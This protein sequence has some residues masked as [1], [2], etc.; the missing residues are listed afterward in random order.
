MGLGLLIRVVGGF[1]LSLSEDLTALGL[2]IV[3][4]PLFLILL[5]LLEEVE[6][7]FLSI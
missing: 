7:G 4:G 5:V 1:S 3:W 6:L 2:A